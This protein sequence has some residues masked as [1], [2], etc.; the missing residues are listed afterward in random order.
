MDSCFEPRVVSSLQ[1]RRVSTVSCGAYHTAAVCLDMPSGDGQAT[2]QH[3][4][5]GFNRGGMLYTWGGAFD[6]Q[7][8]MGNATTSSNEGCLGLPMLQRHE[9]VVKPHPVELPNVVD[10]ACGL[11]YTVVVD[12]GGAVFQM[13]SML[14]DGEIPGCPWEGAPEPTRVKGDLVEAHVTHVSAGT[15]HAVSYTHSP[16]PRDRTRSRMPSSA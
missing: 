10:V 12:A 5:S 14:R 2:Q 6:I 8:T 16:S 3:M 7:T 11:N 13:G 9:G 15:S 1:Q 4:S